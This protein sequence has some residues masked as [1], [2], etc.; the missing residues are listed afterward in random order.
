M[1]YQQKKYYAYHDFQPPT[2]KTKYQALENKKQ[3]NKI[4][5]KKILNNNNILIIFYKIIQYIEKTSKN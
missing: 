5:I 2:H 1:F 4:N 3:H